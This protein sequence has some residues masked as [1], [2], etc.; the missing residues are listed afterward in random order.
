VFRTEGA[1]A[2]QGRSVRVCS[3]RLPAGCRHAA[4]QADGRKPPAVFRTEGARA[5]KGR[6]VRACRCPLPAGC[7]QAAQADV[8]SGFLNVSPSP[9]V[10]PA[11]KASSISLACNA[12]SHV[13]PSPV[14]LSG[15]LSAGTCRVKCGACVGT[16]S[17]GVVGSGVPRT[18][19][20][21]AH[22]FRLRRQRQPQHVNRVPP[23]AASQGR[24]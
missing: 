10:F 18:Q 9:V 16:R 6:S 3:C 2:G 19:V 14:A 5:G 4:G 8:G 11:C 17:A 13:P 21:C 12:R 20:S 23:H 1:R 24:R 15:Q 22:T 7:R